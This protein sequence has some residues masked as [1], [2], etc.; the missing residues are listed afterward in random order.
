MSTVTR[1]LR[2]IN[3][4]N[5]G[6]PTYNAAYLSRYLPDSFETRLLGGSPQASEEHSGF[7]LDRIGMPYIEIPEMSRSVNPLNDWKA[8]QKIV[9]YIKEYQPHLVHTHA[10]KA[11]LLGRLAA[12]HCGVPHIVHTFHGHVFE[13]YFSPLVANGVKI[14]ERQLAKRSSAIITISE[15]QRYDIVERFKIVAPEKAHIIPLGLDLEPFTLEKEQKRSSFRSRYQLAENEF[16][17]AIVGRLTAIKNHRLL[18]QAFFA[19]PPDLPRTLLIVGD[20][21]ERKA[22]EEIVQ[23]HSLPPHINILFTS[24][25][26]NM[27][28][29]M[30]AFDCVVLSSDNEGTPVSLIEA[31]AAG[32]P[33]ISTDVGG[34][35]NCM[36]EN[37]S[38]I[39]V[40]RNNIEA[41]SQ[42]L[43]RMMLRSTEYKDQ[44]ISFAL[45]TFGYQR[46]VK[47]MS[48][49]YTQLLQTPKSR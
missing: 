43:H 9:R 10:A 8:F 17:F 37:K 32:V 28:E 23:S 47:E 33:V 48:A 42:A 35:R 22:L 24:W 25:I 44:G 46:L 6:G 15:A 4:F 14:T 3:R 13:G 39:I 21:E 31:Q 20:G 27:S 45:S 29:V 49:L 12:I 5:L 34:V 7:I 30:P 18:L 26:K 38:G 36:I 41:L 2:I 19:L 40:P 16:V 11:G 1:I